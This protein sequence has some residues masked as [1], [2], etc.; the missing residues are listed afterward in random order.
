MEKIVVIAHDKHKATLCDFLNKREAWFRNRKIIATGRTA[1]F[2]ESN[3]C[4]TPVSYVKK[5]KDGGYIEI[6]K[7]IQQ[8]KVSMVF[9]L[10][11]P[12]IIKPYHEDIVELL[13]ICDNF[14]IPLSTNIAAAELLI[15]GKIR[16]EA[17]NKAKKR[18]NC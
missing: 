10:R 6:S 7:I 11:D 16:M 2:L 12:S 9:F 14:N 15:V 4:L 8:G 17:A 1:E 13:N 5:G 3:N 18:I